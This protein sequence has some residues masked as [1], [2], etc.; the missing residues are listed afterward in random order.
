MLIDLNKYIPLIKK[1]KNF[2]GDLEFSQAIQIFKINLTV[3]IKQIDNDN[4]YYQFYYY[5]KVS[6]SEYNYDLLI[7]VY[8]EKSHHYYKLI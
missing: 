2:S 1:D 7:M 8:E 5:Y 3:Y 6:N 4:T